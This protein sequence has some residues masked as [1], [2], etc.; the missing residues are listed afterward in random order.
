[1]KNRILLIVAITMTTVGFIGVNSILV[2]KAM[3]E[4]TTNNIFI[5]KLYLNNDDIC[6]DKFLISRNSFKIDSKKLK[7]SNIVSFEV[8]NLNDEDK[9]LK[10]TCSNE[11]GIIDLAKNESIFNVAK[12]SSVKKTISFQYD[13]D[14]EDSLKCIV[15]MI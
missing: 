14:Q 7:Y 15:E 8:Y 6:N 10:L 13:S 3:V 9:K 11:N 12:N 1:M 4:E 2:S 5:K